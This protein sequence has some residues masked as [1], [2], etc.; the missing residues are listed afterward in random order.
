MTGENGKELGDSIS[1]RRE[2]RN[3]RNRDQTHCWRCL[4]PEMS[5]IKA[6]LTCCG[7]TWVEMMVVLVRR[8]KRSE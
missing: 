5:E 3:S 6:I 2:A 7:L 4:K 8:K 1:R